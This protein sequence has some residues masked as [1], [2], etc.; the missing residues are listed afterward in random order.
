MK[1]L[2]SLVIITFCAELSTSLSPSIQYLG[3]VNRLQ[4][5]DFIDYYFS[6]SGHGN[7]LIWQ[8]DDEPLSGFQ[9]IEIGEVVVS[10][11]SSFTYTTVLLS[12]IRNDAGLAYEMISLMV[13][14]FDNVNPPKFVILCSNQD[15]VNSTSTDMPGG[16]VIT[17][18]ENSMTVQN[19]TLDYVLSSN[20]VRSRNYTHIFVCGTRSDFQFLEA[21]GPAVGFR[22]NDP[23]GD[24]K[25]V[26]SSSRDT[27]SIL[28]VLMA[29]QPFST[30]TLL[31]VAV[32]SPVNVRCFSD[33]VNSVALASASKQTSTS[34]VSSE[35]PS[36]TTV[37]ARHTLENK[38]D[39]MYYTSK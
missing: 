29:N 26:L 3:R 24:V 17:H 35:M 33:N 20:T 32:D 23:L 39:G 21:V 8:L 18:V 15:G 19:V 5:K 36:I 16:D 34:E 7:F 30:T 14:S 38:N 11:G 2:V 13:V 27:V 22:K 10:R 6:C 37:E 9:P 25:T 4:N 28:G 1:E 31:I 12:S